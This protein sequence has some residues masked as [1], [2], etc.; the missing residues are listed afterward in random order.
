MVMETE[1]D[2]ISINESL[3]SKKDIFQIESDIIVSDI[4]PDV[5]SIIDTNGILCVN[6][7]EVVDGK[8][9]LEGEV[10]S[11]IIYLADDENS[12]VRSLNTCLNFNELIELESF[13]ESM[14][15][16]AHCDLK[17]IEA[18][19]INGRK[20]SLKAIIEV[21]SNMYLESNIDVISNI[22]SIE[23][24]QVL[25]DTQDIISCLGKGTT[26]VNAKDTISID[27]TDDVAEIMKVDLNIIDKE[28]KTSYNKVLVKADAEVKVLYLTE[29]NMVNS[30]NTR[31]PI[32]GFIDM[33]D[34]NDGCICN[35]NEQINNIIIKPNN[36]DEHSIYI[37]AEIEFYIETF[38][39]KQIDIV[40]DLY[41]TVA[42]A[43]S[44]HRNINVMVSKNN[45]T[46]ECK[47]RDSLQKQDLENA[48]FYCMDVK[49]NILKEDIRMGKVIYDGEVVVK[50][51]YSKDE[52]TSISTITIP[53]NT[54]I[55]SNKITTNSLINKEIIVKD[56]NLVIQN[57]RVD[58]S[59]CLE[60][61]IA[62]EE[63]KCLK[64]IENINIEE[65]K[66]KNP[67]SMIIYFVKP[68]DTLWKIAKKFKSTIDDIARVNDISDTNKIEVGEQLYIPKKVSCN[69]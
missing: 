28:I 34:V 10:N 37:E 53:F 40:Q 69:G 33:Q 42:N 51:L 66:E 65:N 44:N 7:K 22:D 48:N 14:N 29:N 8:L 19:I 18:K 56:E 23:N 30:I 16:N 55:L 1:K 5:L 39:N 52:R 50:I 3:G 21:K 4:K 9:K 64:L 49:P 2:K 45:I 63:C 32:M 12:S 54:E 27:E 38:E 15:V 57:D 20:L 58:I 31:I 17:E 67:Y 26:K 59:M 25:K 36:T 13:N 68:G 11:Y 41:S 47:I 61:N 6:K 35:V 60:F 62:I 43:E 46:H 24:M